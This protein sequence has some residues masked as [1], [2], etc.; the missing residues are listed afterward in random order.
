MA[1][2]CGN[3][4]WRHVHGSNVPLYFHAKQLHFDV[5]IAFDGDRVVKNCKM[6]SA[7]GHETGTYAIQLCRQ[8]S[9]GA[10][11]MIN[12]MSISG[13]PVILIV[14]DEIAV[15]DAIALYLRVCGLQVIEV[16]SADE[17]ISFLQSPAKIDLVF[18][19]VRMPGKQNGLGLARWIF[20][21]RPKIPIL[22]TSGDLKWSAAAEKLCGDGS[23]F[24]KPYDPEDLLTQIHARTNRPMAN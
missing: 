1:P 19:D 20:A 13:A 8:L 3:G 22:L 18:S 17:A 7:P 6:R 24:A 21:N 14:E 4:D 9:A 11:A 2:T 16:S 5:A 15:R 23:F 10:R 12:G